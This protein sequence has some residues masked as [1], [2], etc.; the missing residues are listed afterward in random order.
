MQIE[1]RESKQLIGCLFG[2]GIAKDHEKYEMLLLVQGQGPTSLK[3]PYTSI[4]NY[5]SGVESFLGGKPD[6]ISDKTSA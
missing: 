5:V 2:I 1:M 3:E 6:I 4:Y